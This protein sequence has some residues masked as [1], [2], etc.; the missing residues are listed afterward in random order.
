MRYTRISVKKNYVWIWTAVNRE[1]KKF[2]DFV[3][4]NRGFQ[5]GIK[6]WNRVANST[7]VRV[8]TDYWKPYKQII[9]RRIHTQSK[10]ETYTVEGYNSIIRHFLARFKRRTKCYSK[11]LEMIELSLIM[12]INKWNNKQIN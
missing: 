5:T 9:P 3:I 12:L 1:G 4:G 7:P 11:S 2:V 6:I 8:M 10:A